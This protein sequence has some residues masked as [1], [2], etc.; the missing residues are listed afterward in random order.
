M[1][2]SFHSH[3]AGQR[4]TAW[5]AT[6]TPACTLELVAIICRSRC[7]D[8]RNWRGRSIMVPC[9]AIAYSEDHTHKTKTQQLFM[10]ETPVLLAP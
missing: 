4:S 3:L 9:T 8:G 10:M 7:V 5:R 1:N 6:E 2:S